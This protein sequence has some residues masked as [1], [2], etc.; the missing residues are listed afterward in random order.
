MDPFR[1]LS[2]NTAN[3]QVPT[4]EG[5]Y[6][7]GC[8]IQSRREELTGSG[9]TGTEGNS[10]PEL[11]VITR[12][13]NCADGRDPAMEGSADKR[14]SNTGYTVTAE[15]TAKEDARIYTNPSRVIGV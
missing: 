13:F 4:R 9:I 7:R 12:S 14:S 11:A 1:I 15:E 6:T 10:A 2:I 3:N 5:Q 8:T